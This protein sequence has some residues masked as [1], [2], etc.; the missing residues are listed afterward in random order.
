MN[1]NTPYVRE[2]MLKDSTRYGDGEYCVY[3][4]QIDSTC[5]V[6]YVGSGKGYRFNDINPKSR[7]KEFMEIY[8]DNKCS[9]KIVAYGMS[10]EQSL[11]FEKRLIK[12]F[13]KLDMPLVNQQWVDCRQKEYIRR[14][15]ESRRKTRLR[16]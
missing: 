7:S 4:W 10:K 6:F 1:W 13:W 11:D 14:A 2:C 3:F 12:A 15:N 8:N 5:E 9:P 16:G